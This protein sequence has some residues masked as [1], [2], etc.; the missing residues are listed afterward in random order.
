MFWALTIHAVG[1]QHDN[2]TLDIPLSFGTYDEVIDNDLS[3]ICE[4][5]ELAFPANKVIGSSKRIT[6]VKS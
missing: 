2:T 5:S 6:I 4:I 3:T 1:E